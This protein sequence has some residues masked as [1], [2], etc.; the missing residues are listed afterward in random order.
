MAL[1]LNDISKV[2]LAT[3]SGASVATGILAISNGD[4]VNG[5][6]LIAVAVGLEVLREVLKQKFGVEIKAVKPKK[7]T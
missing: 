5:I 4:T 6:I 1:K 2:S 7:K 3:A